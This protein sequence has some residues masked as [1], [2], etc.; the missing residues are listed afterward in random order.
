MPERARDGQRYRN[1]AGVAAQC[2]RRV[3]GQLSPSPWPADTKPHSS[4]PQ[5]VKKKPDG[6]SFAGA[7]DAGVV[8]RLRVSG[9]ERSRHP[10]S[11]ETPLSPLPCGSASSFSA[12][13][14]AAC[15]R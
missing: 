4:Q 15:N 10:C 3:I 6:C 1:S 11:Y 9:V 2:P 13:S 5:L 8:S 12:C 7:K 14:T